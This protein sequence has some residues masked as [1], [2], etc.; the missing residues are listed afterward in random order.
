M[1]GGQGH[2]CAGVLEVID[3]S[4]LALGLADLRMTWILRRQVIG[5]RL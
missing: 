5:L 4:G 2:V 3:P 1:R